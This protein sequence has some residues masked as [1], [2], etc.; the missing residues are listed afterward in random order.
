MVYD[1]GK[2]FMGCGEFVCVSSS[3]WVDIPDPKDN[4]RHDFIL[5]AYVTSLDDLEITGLK[6][7]IND[8]WT[9]KANLS[10]MPTVEQAIKI[11]KGNNNNV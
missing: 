10:E 8:Q 6:V 9:D 5:P 1:H 11:V 4:C 2:C 3:S 7:Y